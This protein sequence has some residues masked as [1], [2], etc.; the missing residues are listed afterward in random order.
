MES[1]SKN[2]FKLVVPSPA[3]LHVYPGEDVTL[4]CR[5]S[6]QTSATAMEVRWLKRTDCVYLFKDGQGTEG[7]NYGG[8]VGILPGDLQTGGVSLRLSR[9]MH[10][11]S[12]LYRC[13]VTHRGHK[14]EETLWLYVKKIQGPRGMDSQSSS[15]ML[16]DTQQLLQ[17]TERLAEAKDAELN[18]MVNRLVETERAL[19]E[20]NAD[21][22]HTREQLLSMEKDLKEKTQTLN[23]L[24]DRLQEK[25]REL[26]NRDKEQQQRI[27]SRDHDFCKDLR[28]PI[29]RRDSSSIFPKPNMSEDQ[30]SEGASQTP[31][32]PKPELRLVLL[33]RNAAEKKAARDAILGKTAVS[34][35]TSGKSETSVGSSETSSST[36]NQSSESK[37]K[38]VG[39]RRANV[40]LT[41]DW[42][43]PEVHQGKLREDVVLCMQLSAPGPHAFILVIPMEHIVIEARGILEDVEKLFAETIWKHTLILF[44]CREEI[45]E[46]TMEEKLTTGCQE[47][48][49]VVEKCGH[50]WHLLNVS[51]ND[52][53]DQVEGLLSKIDD[54]VDPNGT[55]SFYNS[56]TYLEAENQLRE[57]E[58]MIQKE[59]EERREREERECMKQH[60]EELQ[61]CVRVMEVK[62]QEKDEKIET[63]EI[64]IVDLEI[65]LKEERNEERRQELER[66]LKEESEQ[67]AEAEKERQHLREE[68]EREKREK[69]ETHRKEIEEIQENYQREALVEAERNL[70]KI[71]LPELQRNLK[72][73]NA[74]MH[75]EFNRQLQG[76]NTEIRRLKRM[77]TIEEML[78]VEREEGR[79]ARH[80]LSKALGWARQHSSGWLL[81]LSDFARCRLLKFAASDVLLSVSFWNSVLR[82][83]SAGCS[84]DGCVGTVVRRRRP[85]SNWAGL[86]PH[87]LTGAC[88]A[89]HDS[90]MA[91]VQS[92]QHVVPHCC[93]NDEASVFQQQSLFYWLMPDVVMTC[94]R[95]AT[96]LL[97][98]SHL[99]A[100]KVTP[101]SLGAVLL[102][103]AI[104]SAWR[105]LAG[106]CAAAA[107]RIGPLTDHFKLVVPSPAELHVYPGEDVTL[108]CRLSVQTSATPMEVRWLKRTDCVYL[109][110]DGQGTEGK[111]YGGRVGIL[112]GD[113]QTG[114]VSLRLSRIMHSDSGLYRCQVTHRGHKAE[115]TLW[116]YVKKIQGP[117][118]MDSHPSSTMLQDTQQLLQQTERLAEAK[119]AELNE[120]VNRLEETEQA[121]LERNADLK[122]T[123]EQLLSM[124]KD[125]KEKTQTLNFLRDRL[126]EKDR[127]LKNRD[128]EQQQQMLSRD[129]DFCKELRLPIQ[130]RDSSSIFI[131]PN[132][133]ED[134]TSEGASQIPAGPKPELRLVLLGRN[135]AEKKAARD[136]ILGKT[137][138]SSSETSGSRETT[139]SSETSSST[140]NQSSESK[141]KTVGDRRVNVVLTP[142]WFS[143]EVHQGKLR[144]DVA[145]CMQ[146]SAPGPHVFILVIPVEHIVIEARGILEDVEKLFAE[147]IWKHTLIV[148]TCREEITEETEMLTTGCQEFMKVVEKCGHRWH[149]L[150]VCNNDSSDQVEG[151]LRKIEGLVDHNGKDSFYNSETYLEAENQLREMERMIQKEREE[152]REREER[153]LMKQHEE[154]LQECFRVMEVK[155]QEKDEKIEALEIKIVDLE[156]ELEEE[157]NEERRQDLKRQLKEESEQRAE[158]EKERQHLREEM[159]REKREKEETHRIEIEEIQ[160]NY[161]R[162]ALA[163]A[164]RNLMKIILPELQRNLKFSNAKMHGEFNRQLQGKNTEIRRLKRMLTIEEMLRVE[165]EEGRGARHTLSKALG[166]ARQHSS[167]WLLQNTIYL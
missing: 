36:E 76:K 63:L 135:A 41:P 62:I 104:V 71:I 14:A 115:E 165:R 111:N 129:H 117:R 26:K 131:K 98:S 85:M 109:F 18:E 101:A 154:E 73:S 40:V 2:H 58:R 24:R 16:Q 86:P 38:T 72:F 64:K 88:F 39:D 107:F 167:G 43:S 80:T 34:S 151:L 153:E 141:E 48:M 145:L 53:S 118:G 27:S 159:E 33:G 112:P 96:S 47:F 5:L 92:V 29:Q 56:E 37:E 136:A 35:E 125:L 133:S 148:F 4:P 137:V 110:K 142:D 67:R 143:P 22:K 17:Q 140:E 70:M 124:E 123:R 25:D 106:T 132:M 152:R 94:P 83:G 108:P 50:R 66:Q 7:K 144:E 126:Q 164:E 122:H 31:G 150:N 10:S 42:F 100:F 157:R 146:L 99:S 51:K 30:T 15:T 19:L 139:G 45:T 82:S 60:E 160:E 95:N 61:E 11:D 89:L 79:G 155:I 78:R 3:E 52:S 119:D 65:E 163:E 55:D 97:E 28:L 113:L 46:E 91:L 162:E 127:E 49:K 9:V 8:R 12:G 128:K 74:K 166:W 84:S 93:W 149:L 116:L 103:H 138:V 134:Q 69:E 156:R 57:M 121:L 75:G 13:Q 90:L 44:T 147:T 20:R 120:M 81:L 87:S 68:M 32:D 114:G 59:R 130:K 54:L 105:V 102:L 1:H 77:L 21:L 161:Q 6:I 158:A 23:F